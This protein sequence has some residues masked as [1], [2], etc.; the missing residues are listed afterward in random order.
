MRGDQ[1]QASSSSWH[2][3]LFPFSICHCSTPCV[4]MHLCVCLGRREGESGC[5]PGRATENL[6]TLS[7][8]SPLSFLPLCYLLL[9]WSCCTASNTSAL[10]KNKLMYQMKKNK[11][12][13]SADA[14][15]QGGSHKADAI[16]QA[17]T[18]HQWQSCCAAECTEG[19]QAKSNSIHRLSWAPWMKAETDASHLWIRQRGGHLTY[20]DY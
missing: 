8:S 20:T 5:D 10:W 19:S 15:C 17:Q 9:L 12:F 7:W 3:Y 11:G 2:F 14:R 16:C 6:S 1:V 18:K 13:F 4:C